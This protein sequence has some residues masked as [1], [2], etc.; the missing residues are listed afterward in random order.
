MGRWKA[1]ICLSHYVLNV[2]ESWQAL[3]EENILLSRKRDRPRVWC[4][5]WVQASISLH[6]YL[7]K[8]DLSLSLIESG[9]CDLAN[10]IA[11]ADGQLLTCA[12][13]SWIRSVMF[14]H[15][16]IPL[17]ILSLSVRLQTRVQANYCCHKWILFLK[18][19][20]V[21]S[22]KIN[23]ALPLSQCCKSWWLEFLQHFSKKKK[24]I[25]M[26]FH[27]DQSW[28]ISSLPWLHEWLPGFF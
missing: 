16:F 21:W 9:A 7:P 15:Q 28:M 13:M 14:L 23:S 25:K 2:V 8:A 12:V 11:V 27:T 10:S 24:K 26:Y 4:V 18:K 19:L 20:L 5:F 22:W 1:S 6:F 17:F 3:I